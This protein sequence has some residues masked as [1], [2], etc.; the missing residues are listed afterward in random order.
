MVELTD[1]LTALADRGSDSTRHDGAVKR[2]DLSERPRSD[3]ARPYF[4]TLS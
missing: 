3:L 1:L 2:I 4:C